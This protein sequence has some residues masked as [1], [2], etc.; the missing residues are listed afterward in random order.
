MKSGDTPLGDLY[1]RAAEGN[2]FA[3]SDRPAFQ[4]LADE[5]A[6]AMGAAML[7]RQERARSR[8]MALLSQSALDLS[9]PQI[10]VDL[11][12]GLIVRRGMKLLDADDGGLWLAAESG[13]VAH[14][15]SLGQTQPL[16]RL[17]SPPHADSFLT[18]GENLALAGRAFAAGQTIRLD[19]AAGDAQARSVMA[20]PIN[21]QE[22]TVGVLVL[23]RSQ[24]GMPFSAED[25]RNAQLFAGLAAAAIENARFVEESQARVGEL[26]TLNQIAQALAA[27]TGLLPLFDSVR[28]EV[29]RALGIHSLT[30]ALYDAAAGQ[31]EIPYHFENGRGAALAPPTLEQGVTGAVILTR[32]PL[33][34]GSE[35]EAEKLGA[36]IAG[37]TARSYLGVPIIAGETV[38]GVLAVQDHEQQNRFNDSDARL[39]TTIATQ[40][41]LAVQNVRLLEETQER[42]GQLSAINRVAAAASSVLNLQE[43]L[44]TIS[45]EL[46]AVF[47]AR[48]TGI[49]LLDPDRKAL[50]VVA[51]YSASPDEPSALGIV[52]PLENNPSTLRVIETRRSL[53]IPDTQHNPLTAP[54]HDIMRARGT[55]CLLIVPLLTRGE[56]V[57]TIGID[58]NQPDREFT[59]AEATLAETIAGQI[60]QAVETGQLYQQLQRRAGQL[61]A[62]AEVSRAAISTVNPDELIAR[63]VELIRERFDLYY[64][65]LFLVDEP[66][67]WAELKHATGEAGQTLLGRKHRLEVGGQSMVGAAVS[68]RKARIALDV[69][70]EAV[71]FANPLLPD[72]HS[73]MALPLVVGDTVLG[74]LDVQSTEINA[75]S[76]ADITVLQT[77]ADQIAIAIQNARL[78]AQ[79]Q[80]RV[81]LE[82]QINEISRK[83]RRSIDSDSIMETTLRELNGLLGA[84]RAV[85]ALGPEGHR[86]GKREGGMEGK[87]Q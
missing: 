17:E 38:L 31:I 60:A 12:V 78:Y 85:A 24:P 62:A 40:M 25:E 49:A 20:V 87:A 26:Y 53:I 69:G 66:G 76:E 82:Q 68:T 13:Q 74:A 36:V 34:I 84:R 45:R 30:I 55:E 83:I 65:A 33:V 37:R 28:I 8:Q 7:H 39:L 35:E 77:M 11:A 44:E 41:G 3:E 63:T 70:R 16:G 46:V 27:Q 14:K 23:G 21:W 54:I 9:G 80:R 5:I 47:S 4:A 72:T 15:L 71:R 64:A 2:T 79:V 48:N 6:F 52:I 43:V 73:E 50:T 59:Q 61:T 32:Q 67:Q 56:V 51:D 42:A 19:A 57:G 10:S 58:T 1:L 22:A 75:F 81:R 86:P 18:P 29:A